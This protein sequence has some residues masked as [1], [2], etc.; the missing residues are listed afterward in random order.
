MIKKLISI[1]VFSLALTFVANA[2][3]EKG[4][5]KKGKGAP[6]PAKRAAMIMKADSD[7]DGKVSAAE[8]G[9]SKMAENMNKRKEGMA[10]AFFAKAD[11]DKDGS[12][13]KEEAEKIPARGKGAGKGKGKGKGA[14]K[15]DS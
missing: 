10:D 7:G 12:L 15:K 9:K 6:D 2:A 4:G 8:F 3:D 11:A 14:D 13:S 5:D 1:S